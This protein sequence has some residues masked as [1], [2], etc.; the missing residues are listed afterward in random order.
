MRAKKQNLWPPDLGYHQGLRRGI[1][2]GEGLTPQR[3]GPLTLTEGTSH[4][5]SDCVS[6]KV[7]LK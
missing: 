3:R 5:F 6:Q 4:P 1:L 2:G 7:C